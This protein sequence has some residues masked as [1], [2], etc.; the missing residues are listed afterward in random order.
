MLKPCRCSTTPS[1]CA[2]TLPLHLACLTRGFLK[3][4][5]QII[6]IRP[7]WYWNLWFWGT[8]I[9]GNLYKKEGSGWLGDGSDFAPE[10]WR[11]TVLRLVPDASYIWMDQPGSA[12]HLLVPHHW[13][14]AQGS[15]VEVFLRAWNRLLTSI[16]PSSNYST[17]QFRR[18]PELAFLH[19]FC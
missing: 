14:H 1:Q 18:S 7:F 12:R 9:L 8:L 10:E 17:T 3:W 19:S 11:V 13:S 16:V 6:Q 5:Y 15:V 2:S 4:W